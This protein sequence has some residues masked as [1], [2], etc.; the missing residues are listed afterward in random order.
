MSEPVLD[1]VAE[2]IG[3]SSVTVHTPNEQVFGSA[4]GQRDVQVWFAPG[5][6]QRVATGKL[7]EELATLARLLMVAG[8]RDNA[9]I[10]AAV[11]GHDLTERVPLGRRAEAYDRFLR[12]LTVEAASDDGTVSVTAVGQL[13]FVVRIEPGTLDRVP[14]EVFEA[15]CGQAATRLVAETEIAAARAR[16]ETFEPIPGVSLADL[17]TRTARA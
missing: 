12:E 14:Q 1:P 2:A 9:R 16:W 10:T 6:Y 15:S 4:T 8:L 11:T 17:D 3:V 5:H 7:A 13:S